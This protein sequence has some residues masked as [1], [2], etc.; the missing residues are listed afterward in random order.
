MEP[1]RPADV[2]FGGYETETKDVGE[3]FGRKNRFLT[4]VAPSSE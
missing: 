2:P 3:I 4:V 1:L